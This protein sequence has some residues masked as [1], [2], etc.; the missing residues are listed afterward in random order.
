MNEDTVESGDGTVYRRDSS[1]VK[2]YNKPLEPIAE[3]EGQQKPGLDGEMA[4]SGR[5]KR[6]VKLPEKLN[7]FI[8]DKPK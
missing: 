1:F 8:M 7:D 5:P 3:N 6:V 4:A 2:S